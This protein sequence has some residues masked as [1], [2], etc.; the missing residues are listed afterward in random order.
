M[1]PQVLIFIFRRDL[2]IIDNLALHNLHKAHPSIP[3]IPM[4]IFN[5]VQIDSSKSKYYSSAAVE[6]MVESLHDLE[7]H[8]PK[9]YYFE[10][11]DEDVLNQ[12]LKQFQVE[13]IAWN[14]DYTPFA[15]KRD[16]T[17]KRWCRDHKIDYITST[18]DYNLMDF[19]YIKTDVGN[20]YEV[21]TPFY[22]K[23]IKTV[24]KIA[25]PLAQSNTSKYIFYNKTIANPPQVKNI[26][27]YIDAPT[28]KRYI[29]GGRAN[30]LQ[31]LDKIKRKEFQAYDHERD[32]PALDKTTH[33]SAYLKFGNVSV[34][35]VFWVTHKTYGISH[36]LIREYI[37]R[38]FYAYMINYNDKMLQHQVS[39]EANQ[40]MKAKY[41][42]IPWNNNEIKFKAWCEG[43]TGFPIVD[44][45]MISLN[46]TG[47][48]HNRLRM[49]VAMFLIKDLHID[50]TWGERYFA[51]KLVDYDPCSNSGG[52]QWCASVGPDA[53]PSYRIFNPWIQSK[54]FDQNVI[55]IKKWVPPLTQVSPKHIHEWFE[56]HKKYEHIKYPP[57]LLDHSIESHISIEIFKQE[58]K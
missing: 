19:E 27:K 22:R 32:Y 12:V 33:L 23:V 47:F 14:E 58:T 35:E 37:W 17:L 55:F 29:K 15:K 1:K 44:A 57:P 21:F 45:A 25:F 13:C 11:K 26:S 34:R 8:L 46:Q 39:K 4:F 36:G 54:K 50:W 24:N 56:Y 16:E 51:S 53:S 41:A 49:I 9:L 48:M 31:I 6:F 3:I 5:P 42:H 2:R 40:P 38:F 10:G 52:W 28:P 7:T 18:C 43:K 30:A 20:T